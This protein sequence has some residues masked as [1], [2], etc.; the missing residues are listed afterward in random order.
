[1]V[2][3]WLAA[4]D[5]ASQTRIARAIGV[6]ALEETP[7]IPLGQFFIRTVFRKSITGMLQG[8]CPYPWNIRPA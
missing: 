2:Q 3:D 7:S 5:E 1:M 4:P 8:P 6:L